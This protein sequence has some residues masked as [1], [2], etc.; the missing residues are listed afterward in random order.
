MEK[1]LE[2]LTE[3]LPFSFES[4]DLDDRPELEDKYGEL[5]PVLELNGQLVCHYH[6]DEAALRAYLLEF[7]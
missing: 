5:I 7:G 4:I 1:A 2:N 3:S 6:L